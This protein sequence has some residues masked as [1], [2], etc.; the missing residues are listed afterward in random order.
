M[1]LRTTELASHWSSSGEGGPLEAALAQVRAAGRDVIDLVGATPQENGLEFPFPQQVDL[2]AAAARA[3]EDTVRRYHPDSQGQLAAREAIAAWYAR[4]A[5]PAR[6]ANLLLTPGTSFA[7]FLAFRLLADLGD[8]VLVP[9]PGYPLFDDLAQLAGLRLRSYHLARR[10]DG[11]WRPDVDDLAFQVTPRTRIIVA[12]SPH[13]PTGTVWSADDLRRTGALCREHALSFVFDEV[14]SEFLLPPGGALPRP[15][16]ADFP[17]A[18][19][20]NGFSK[21]FSLPGWKVAWMLARGDDDVVAR[22]LRAAAH[23]SDTFLAVSE[24]MQAA[25]PEVLRRGEEAAS[26]PLAAEYAKR[27]IFALHRLAIP[28]D[29]ADGGVYLCVSIPEKAL[30]SAAHPQ[31]ANAPRELG[32]CLRLLEE[33]GVLVHPGYYY[34]L[35]E[36]YVVFTCV[37]R[38]ERLAKGIEALNRLLT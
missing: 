19:L 18:L 23:G 30:A 32:F 37:A 35:P 20:L 6:A 7:Y 16:D 9:R 27:R 15:L 29:P 25:I 10:T 24:W 36:G 22:F 21:M 34:D 14:F 28:P 11:S 8:E 2:L 33:H 17:L 1:S 5:E 13:N 31:A 38:E 26:R 12:V 4:R 3:N